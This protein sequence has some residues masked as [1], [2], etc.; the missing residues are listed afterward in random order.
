[1]NMSERPPT[2][3][4]ALLLL[5]AFAFQGTRA[6]W[7]PDEGRYSAAGLNMLESGDYLIPTIDG[8]HPHLTKPPITYWALAASFGALGRNEW[9]ARLPG[10][11]A[12]VGTG[13]L[14]FGLGRRFCPT[15]PWLPALVYGLSLAPFMGA[16]VIST[17]VLLVFFETLAMYAFVRAWPDGGPVDRRWAR[18]MWLA[19]GL[20]FMTKGPPGL[21]PLLAMCLMLALRDRSALRSMFDPLGL[22]GFALVSF[23]WF[24]IVIA[25]DPSRLGY[26]VGY[27][28][29][30][31]VFTSAHDRNAEWYGALLVYGPVF[32]F[33]ALP[34]WPMALA[35]ASGPRDAWAGFRIRLSTRDRDWLLLAWWFLLPLAVFCLARSRLQLYVLPLFVPLSLMLARPLAKWDWLGARRTAVIAALTAIALLTLKGVAGHVHAGRDARDM[36]GAIRKLIDPRSVDGIVFVGMRPFYG[37]HLYLDLPIEGVQVGSR[38]N[39]YSKFVAEEDLCAELAVGENNVYA[40]KQNRAEGFGAAVLA[41]DGLRAASIG[42]FEA[43]GNRIALFAVDSR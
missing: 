12:F 41:C 20:A 7:E 2:W 6:I 42:H 27:E 38:R 23:T 40:M 31:R 4:I 28:V 43:D 33:G 37:L 26:F 15:R 36:A 34:W 11:L 10:A 17:D 30:D 14:V 8:E 25:Q 5:L 19:W 29:Y 18:F 13:L 3:L 32:L 24:G 16:N 39:D 21:L 22:L 35:A 9:A 1:M